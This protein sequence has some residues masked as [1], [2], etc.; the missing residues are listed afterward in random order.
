MEPL[1]DDGRADILDELDRELFV[2]CRLFKQREELPQVREED[3][4][5]APLECEALAIDMVGGVLGEQA[6]RIA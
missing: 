6:F 3:R 2:G 1:P 4:F 5:D